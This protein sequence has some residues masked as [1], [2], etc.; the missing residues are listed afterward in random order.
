MM[1]N[2]YDA[3]SDLRLKELRNKLVADTAEKAHIA[4]Q[5]NATFEELDE[6]VQN[7]CWE[8]IEEIEELGFEAEELCE[9]INRSHTTL[10]GLLAKVYERYLW[11][12]ENELREKAVFDFLR[13]EAKEWKI[14]RFTKNTSNLAL[15]IKM[16]FCGISKHQ[17]YTYKTVLEAALKENISSDELLA[18]IED[19]GGVQQIR[20]Q[21]GMLD[22]ERYEAEKAKTLE[23]ETAY[24]ERQAQ[25][26][27]TV[28]EQAQLI[29]K[30]NTSAQKAI[31][32]K[33]VAQE[34]NKRNKKVQN[35]LNVY[36][37]RHNEVLASVQLQSYTYDLLFTE[38][39]KKS[40]TKLLTLSVELDAFNQIKVL[41]P[42]VFDNNKGEKVAMHVKF[43]K[44]GKPQYEFELMEE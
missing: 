4:Q 44:K 23:I 42:I 27:K 20:E 1:L 6:K 25:N 15:M 21:N 9:T 14:C 41:S 34:S 37:E 33:T 10:Y 12:C 19:K 35:T 29:S 32:A 7:E 5:M 18:F 28:R 30:A 3:K 13:S 11:V 39:K 2:D 17:T 36:R 31:K 8:T 24:I 26:A 40:F 38:L 22:V 16:V 43:D